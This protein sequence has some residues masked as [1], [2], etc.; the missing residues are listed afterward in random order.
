MRVQLEGRI[1]MGLLDCKHD[2]SETWES[3]P[4]E[5]R[6]IRGWLEGEVEEGTGELERARHLAVEYIYTSHGACNLQK[7]GSKERVC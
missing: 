1:E 4:A 5:S 7:V 3:L 2:T 6:R